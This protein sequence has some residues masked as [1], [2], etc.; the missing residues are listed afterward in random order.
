MTDFSSCA[1]ACQPLIHQDKESMMAFPAPRLPLPVFHG[2]YLCVLR[3]KKGE[4]RK[5]KGKGKK[6]LDARYYIEE[7]TDVPKKPRMHYLQAPIV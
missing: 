1:G 3:S 7:S 4:G 2:S 6:G 5:G